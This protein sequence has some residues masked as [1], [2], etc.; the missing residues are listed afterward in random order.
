ADVPWIITTYLFTKASKT[1]DTSKIRRGHWVT[2]IVRNIRLFV[3][4]EIK[5]CLTP[6]KSGLVDKKAF[7]GLIDK[8]TNKLLP[9]DKDGEEDEVEHE[10]IVEQDKQVE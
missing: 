8:E 6:L 7:T 2:K 10:E 5:K 3:T 9:P 4:L 1:R